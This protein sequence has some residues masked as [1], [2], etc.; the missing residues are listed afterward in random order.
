VLCLL[1]YVYLSHLTHSAIGITNMTN[2]KTFTTRLSIRLAIFK[3][4]KQVRKTAKDIEST[5]DNEL[6]I[7]IDY[8]SHNGTAINECAIEFLV[9]QKGNIPSVKAKQAA[10]LIAT[11]ERLKTA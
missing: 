11:I 8:N 2:L 10:W 4:T 1:Y 7:I 6:Q 9:Y 5:I 3:N